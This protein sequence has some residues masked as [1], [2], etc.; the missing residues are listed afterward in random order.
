MNDI[1]IFNNI[2]KLATLDEK[3]V[4]KIKERLPEYHRGKALIGHQTSQTSYSLQTMNMI[5]DSPLSRMKQCLAQID[6][7]YQ[8]LRESY[9]KI[10][11]HK[12]EIKQIIKNKDEKSQLR[13]KELDSLISII[14][15]SMQTALRQIGMF[16]DMYDSIKQN[17]NIPDDWTESDYEKQEI[18]N[19]IRRAFR[20]SIQSVQSSGRLSVASIEFF[21][22][23]GIHPTRAEY[24]TT[25]YLNKCN[26]ETMK[27]NKLSIRAMHNFLDDMVKEFGQEY[28]IALE[29]LG[30]N[31]IGSEEFMAKGMTK[32]Q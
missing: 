17:N 31:G 12:L 2:E 6:K 25:L 9:F 18:E 15:E 29:R 22:Q 14:S 19:M 23:L 26:E 10:E 28:N 21:E 30:L 7:K 8:A 13:V 27:G 20:L 5:S 11:E 3:Q 4:A 32:P 16:Q 1:T 24:L